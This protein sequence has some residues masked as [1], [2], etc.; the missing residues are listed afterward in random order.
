[1]ALSLY[2]LLLN[3]HDTLL[4]NVVIF[5]TVNCISFLFTN[6]SFGQKKSFDT[7]FVIETNLSHMSSNN[8]SVL[9]LASK[10]SSKLSVQPRN[11]KLKCCFCSKNIHNKD[12]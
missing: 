8:C 5:S 7:I 4:I 10:I 11:D 9:S 6:I 1:M 2:T 3:A 12:S